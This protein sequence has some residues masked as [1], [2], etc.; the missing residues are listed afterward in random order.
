MQVLQAFM[1]S[2]SNCDY[3]AKN[4]GHAALAQK[5]IA[6]V[7]ICRLLECDVLYKLGNRI[8]TTIR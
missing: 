1:S 4:R 2:H 7:A 3:D 5:T 6:A 8:T